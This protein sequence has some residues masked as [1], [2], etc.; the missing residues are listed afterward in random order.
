M[1][2]KVST[3]DSPLLKSPLFLELSFLIN[4]R[5]KE[6]FLSTALQWINK[7]WRRCRITEYKNLFFIIFFLG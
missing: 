5:N 1:F 4:L 2:N 6:A 7:T 3:L